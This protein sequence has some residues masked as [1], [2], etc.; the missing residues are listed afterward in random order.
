MNFNDQELEKIKQQMAPRHN[1]WGVYL[2]VDE[3]DD[4][5]WHRVDNLKKMTKRAPEDMRYIWSNKLK[6]LMEKVG[7]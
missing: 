5:F 7:L 4:L 2:Q 1:Q 3:P 6:K